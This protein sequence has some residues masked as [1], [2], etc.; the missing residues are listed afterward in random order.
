VTR[1]LLACSAMMLAIACII[2]DRDIQIDPGIDNLFAVRIVE[3]APRLAE[4]D[5]LCDVDDISKAELDYCAEVRKDRASGLIEPTTGELCI[6]SAGPRSDGYAIDNFIIYA[7]DADREFDHPKDTVYGVA[8]L[9]PELAGDDPTSAVAYSNYWQPGRAGELIEIRHSDPEDR[10]EPPAGRRLLN[11]WRFPFGNSDEE[12]LHP[13]HVDLC[14][15]NNGKPVTPGLHNLRFM[16]T[17]REF[18]RPLAL[19]QG[20]PLKS[21]DGKPLYDPQQFG[22]PDLA[23]GA[24]YA[25]ID[26]VFRCIDSNDPEVKA[27]DDEQRAN[28]KSTT[29][30]CDAP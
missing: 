22:V 16:V 14:N 24:T 8:L 2:P 4:M 21:S 10:T 12:V 26:Y 13:Y 7:E 18:F 1:W 11:L 23:A 6:C 5:E 15:D 3:R 17:D 20:G 28:G 25:T 27:F 30:N 19:S 9:D 29:C